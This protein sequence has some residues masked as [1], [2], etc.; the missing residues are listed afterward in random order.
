MVQFEGHTG[1]YIYVIHLF[2][3]SDITVISV[4]KILILFHSF[5]I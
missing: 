3:Y 5:I 1:V 4:I 2:T